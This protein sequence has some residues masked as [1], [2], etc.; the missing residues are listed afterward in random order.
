MIGGRA[1]PSR[2]PINMN[3]RHINCLYYVAIIDERW[4]QSQLQLVLDYGTLQF[5]IYFLS[6]LALLEW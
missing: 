3:F 4:E 2:L 5:V 1:A 6:A